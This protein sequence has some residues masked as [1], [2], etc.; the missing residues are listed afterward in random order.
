MLGTGEGGA[1][2]QTCL[3][4]SSLPRRG[5]CSPSADRT[6]RCCSGG[7]AFSSSISEVKEPEHRSRAEG[8]ENGWH[9]RHK[10]VP[11]TNT[12]GQR[13]RQPGWKGLMNA[14][15]LELVLEVR[16]GW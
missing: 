6:G 14:W 8:F 7:P 13:E 5:C 11:A 3:P 15:E 2:I 9:R 1:G 12:E 16:E 4:V 10:S